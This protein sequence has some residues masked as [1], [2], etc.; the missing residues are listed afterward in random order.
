MENKI[1]ILKSTNFG[2][3]IAEQETSE[4][5]NYF[6]K[7][8]LWEQIMDDE[9]DIV[10]G[11][12]GSGKSA[13]YNYLENQS[14]NI[15]EKNG[16]L[17]LAENPRGTLAFKGLNTSPPTGESEFKSIWKLYFVLIAYQKLLEYDCDDKYMKIVMEK[18]QQSNLIP[19]RPGFTYLVKMVRDYVDRF[20]LEPNVSLNDTTGLIDNVGVKIS[21]GEPSVQ[22]ADKGVVS[23]DY[24][25]E[26]LNNSLEKSG[27]K[28]WIAIDRLDAIFQE[29]FMLE[30]TALK[31]LFQVYIDL[32]QYENIRLLIFFRDDIWNRII[33]N[34][35][36]ESSHL[37][38][39]ELILWDEGSLFH[40]IVSRLTKN[41]EL[42]LEMGYTK[43]QLE[44]KEKQTEFFY[45]IFPK[46]TERNGEFNFKW[47]LTK[48]EDG[49]GNISPRELIHLLN[50]SIK[51]EI[52]KVTENGDEQYDYLISEESIWKALK[53]VSKTKLDTVLSEYPK[54][55]PFINR[56]KGK[57]VSSNFEELKSYWEI[58]KKDTK[59]IIENLIKIGVIWNKN[60]NKAGKKDLYSIPTLYRG[61]LGY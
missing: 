44:N 32:M 43:D 1:K 37:T 8:Y 26:C 47:L 55:K 56:L 30:A 28:V 46:E 7:T 52:K 35:F 17:A 20:T 2:E 15:F 14:D 59:I 12:K 13:L 45:S 6:L 41:E 23:V 51:Q 16:I 11:C 60:E 34:G 40:L 39:K 9:I 4:L 33:D 25:L 57:K 48:I 5:A 21:L 54:L 50:S 27:F 18:L 49:N 38:K 36:R 3:R 24:L 19:R 31:T 42:I 61:G 58:S 10:F 29:N 53:Q 22:S